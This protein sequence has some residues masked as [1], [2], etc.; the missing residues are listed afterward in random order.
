M[1]L[2][3]SSQSE[4]IMRSLQ[5]WWATAGVD[6]DF[7]DT[8]N[9]LLRK[10]NIVIDTENSGLKPS[11]EATDSTQVR[12]E[13]AEAATA[14]QVPQDY[15]DTLDAF[16]Q[17]LAVSDNL[18]E[19]T[20]AKNFVAPSNK[21]EPDIMV[22]VAM[23]ENQTSDDNPYLDSQSAQLLGNMMAA[24]NC[25]S[26]GLCVVSLALAR[27]IDGRIG[28]EYKSILKERMLH[29]IEL[30]RPKR[31][32]IFGDIASQV[33]LDQ[34]LLVARQNKQ[35]INHVSSNTEAIV[36]FH[37]RILLERPEFKAEAW[38]DLQLLTRISAS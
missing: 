15:P 30:I 1:N 13:A 4:E 18:I 11:A 12:S 14:A 23:P 2:G 6:L 5:Y 7:S 19:R 24:I 33:M 10:A 36:T 3:T 31:L 9:A 38:K 28:A 27:S 20:W 22:I 32:I 8:P 25:D 29:L 21:V 34:N 35:L 26:E 17:W 16:I 37:P